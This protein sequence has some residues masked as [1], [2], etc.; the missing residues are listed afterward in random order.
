[1]TAAAAD[2]SQTKQA[3]PASDACLLNRFQLAWA[4]AATRIRGRAVAFSQRLLRASG[5]RS[6]PGGGPAPPAVRGRSFIPPA[7]KAS[8]PPVHPAGEPAGTTAGPR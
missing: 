6:R 4:T 5:R 1:M 8:S 2:M 3:V 7:E